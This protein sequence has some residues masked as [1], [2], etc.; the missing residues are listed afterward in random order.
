LPERLHLPAV[1]VRRDLDAICPMSKNGVC[2][3]CESENI[4]FVGCVDSS[5]DRCDSGKSTLD[6]QEQEEHDG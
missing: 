4:S 5:S 6:K 1:E 2:Q 3:M